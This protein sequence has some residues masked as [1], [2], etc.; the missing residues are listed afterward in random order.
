MLDICD[1]SHEESCLAFMVL[2]I[3]ECQQPD[4]CRSDHVCNNTIGSYTCEC[5]PGFTKNPAS[6]N[7]LEPVCDGEEISTYYLRNVK[8]TNADWCSTL[9]QGSNKK[10]VESLNDILLY[11]TTK[12]K[13]LK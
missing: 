3:D 6:Q 8:F 1:I 13:S 2:D 11:Q 9:H 4:A 5:G 7:N 10:Q 12:Q